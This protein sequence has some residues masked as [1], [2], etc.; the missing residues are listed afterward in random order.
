M[1]LKFS[2][3]VRGND[4]LHCPQTPEARKVSVIRFHLSEVY[5]PRRVGSQILVLQLPHFLQAPT[6]N[7]KDLEKSTNSCNP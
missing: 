6:Q 4:F 5:T 7:F 2:K 3:F 1:K